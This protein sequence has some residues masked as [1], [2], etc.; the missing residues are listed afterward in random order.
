MRSGTTALARLL[1]AHPEIF[2]APQK[3]VHF[4]D[5]KFEKGLDYYHRQ[6]SGA[7]DERVS[8]EATPTYMYDAAAVSRMA[9]TVPHARLIAILRNPVDRAYSH[10]WHNRA[11]GKEKL[12]FPDAV[13]AEPDRLRC[14]DRFGRMA[15]SYVDR[16][17]YAEQLKRVCEHYPRES[18][19]V[20]L[21]DDLR[22]SPVETYRSL[23]RFLGVNEKFTPPN[24]GER[25]N[26]Y[27]TFRS[28][29]I[30]RAGRRTLPLPLQRQVA[31]LNAR[32]VADYEPMEASV[33]AHL[34]DRFAGANSELA[35]WL[36]R[37]LTAWSI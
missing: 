32:T 12:P 30:R 23:F 31:R 13:A 14:A 3:E 24:V 18:L 15:Y 27:V 1:G 20:L 33:R 9:A 8:G 2:M 35:K 10:Y 17:H 16:G 25:I 19:L 22:D 11:L 34:L 29:L 7:R 21:F 6:F 28:H 5:G 4:F 37:D 26:R 36:D